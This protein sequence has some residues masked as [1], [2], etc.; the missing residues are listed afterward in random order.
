MMMN[1]TRS[2]KVMKN[3]CTDLAAVESLEPRRLLSGDTL[4]TLAKFPNNPSQG[5][6][7]E[8]AKGDLFFFS[9][10]VPGSTGQEAIFELAKGSRTPTRVVTLPTG[11][12]ANVS[13]LTI[14]SAGDLFGTDRSD[15][16]NSNGT[17]WEIVKGSDS[18]FTLASFTQ[19]QTGAF[20]NQAH[21]VIDGSGNIFGTCQ[22]GGASGA[23]T[24]WELRHGT[25]TIDELASLPSS[26]VTF[27]TTVAS[28]L[29]IDAAGNLY[30]TIGA[31]VGSTGV[32]GSVWELQFQ[33]QAV[34]TLA[35]FNG[36]DGSD[37][38]SPLIV[39]SSG[40]IFGVTTWGGSLSDGIHPSKG[41]GAL[42]EI[43]AG[44]R[45]ITPLASFTGANG[46]NPT[47]G[48]VADSN[49]NLFGITKS[50]SLG[51]STNG[52]VFELPKN[53]SKTTTLFQL[54]QSTGIQPG[55]DLFINGSGD[56][57]DATN[58]SIY[59]LTPPG[60]GG[61]GTGAVSGVLS[62][63]LPASAVAGKKVRINQNLT[64]TDT[65]T[66]PVIGAVT[67]KLFLATGTTIDSN[68]I[69][70]GFMGKHAQLNPHGHFLLRFP[71]AL[72][73]ASVPAGAYHVVA[74][75]TDPHGNVSEVASGGTITVS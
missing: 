59:Q 27:G 57:I 5:E 42:F 45:A 71:T 66:G 43:V 62:G 54:T 72:I 24:V 56:L 31:D 63:K 74:Q 47:G 60:G 4:S 19:N 34:I 65:G 73:S 36:I 22:N 6:M 51:S 67:A 26:D 2:L 23:G 20:P 41:D 8:D 39:D 40:N 52:V 3:A 53:A 69:K 1:G 9:T 44:S 10:T 55:S 13:G 70:I 46:T 49:G 17:L 38:Q 33:T 35:S 7:V 21:L 32:F 16:V 61:G 48:L 12:G 29:A 50:S 64:I 15:G 30:G 28:G 68:S 37:P 14:D 11:V 75:I 18:F 58:F 25:R